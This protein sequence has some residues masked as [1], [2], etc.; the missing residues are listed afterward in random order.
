MFTRDLR[1]TTYI[2]GS[3]EIIF[4]LIADMPKFKPALIDE[5]IVNSGGSQSCTSVSGENQ[6]AGRR[7]IARQG[8]KPTSP[9]CMRHM[10]KERNGYNCIKGA[11]RIE[12]VRIG[13]RKNGVEADRFVEAH[14]FCVDVR[15]DNNVIRQHSHQVSR[16][17]TI[18]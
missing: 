5:S 2:T 4:D 18:T 14:S 11:S 10:R 1:F 17:A 8:A 12:R 16:D 6:F 3:P 15:R 7:E 13:C 9:R